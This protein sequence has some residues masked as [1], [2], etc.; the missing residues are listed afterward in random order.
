M[1]RTPAGRPAYVVVVELFLYRGDQWLLIRRS[2]TETHGP[3]QLAGIGGKVEIA[4]ADVPG[5]LEATVW[6]EVLEE[7]GVDLTGLALMYVASNFFTSDDGDPMVNIVFTGELPAAVSPYPAAPDEVDEVLWLTLDEAL[8][9]PSCPP[10]IRRS[11]RQSAD[12]AGL[13]AGIG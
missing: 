10:W 1:V 2:M 8:A 6:R 5:V 13:T 12:A 11:L 4:G 7:V 9:E 3:G